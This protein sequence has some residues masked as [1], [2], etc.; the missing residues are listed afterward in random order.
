MRRPTMFRR[1]LSVL[2]GLLAL[3]SPSACDSSDHPTPG[4]AADTASDIAED[5]AGPAD[6]FIPPYEPK[7][8]TNGAIVRAG[9]VVDGDTL[10][11]LVGQYNPVAYSVRLLGIN[12]PECSKRDAI[13]SEGVRK[14]CVLSQGARECDAWSNEHHSTASYEALKELVE[15]KELKVSCDGVAVGSWCSTDTF[16][17]HLVY[18]EVDGKDVSTELARG[19]NAWSFTAF[20][21]SKRAQICQAEYDARAANV[22][23]WAAGSVSH[24]LS[25]MC[26]ETEEWYERYHDKDCDK[27]LGL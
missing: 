4:D 20:P 25:L 9:H 24:V 6:T 13:T 2:L 3:A 19:G 18:L 17:R 16:D 14:A 8:L 7:E 15:G 27:A 1:Q 5:T 11:V 22:G 26:P 21:S 23:M 12:S 10:D